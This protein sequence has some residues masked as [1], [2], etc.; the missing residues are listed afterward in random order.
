VGSSKGRTEGWQENLEIRVVS[1]PTDLTAA[2]TA[3]KGD[4]VSE[5][6]LYLIV[7]LATALTFCLLS[8]AIVVFAC[9]RK[10]REKRCCRVKNLKQFSTVFAFSQYNTFFSACSNEFFL[11]LLFPSSLPESEIVRKIKLRPRKRCCRVSFPSSLPYSDPRP[12]LQRQLTFYL[13]SSS[14]RPPVENPPKS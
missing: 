12:T 13:S 8:A 4:S 14:P 5:C 11:L 1:L 3:V 2:A 6:R 9:I 7:T 10:A